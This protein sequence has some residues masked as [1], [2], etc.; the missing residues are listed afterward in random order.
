MSQPSLRDA[1]FAWANSNAELTGRIK[2]LAL[3]ESNDEDPTAPTRQAALAATAD[4]IRTVRTTQ[5]EVTRTY[6]DLHGEIP[7]E[8]D[9]GPAM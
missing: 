8:L 4:A 1:L 3:A 9:A 2:E 5:S 7:P 6:R